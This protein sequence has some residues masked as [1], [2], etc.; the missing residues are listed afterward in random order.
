MLRAKLNSGAA[1]RDGE[2]CKFWR[3]D[4]EVAAPISGTR[5][6]LLLIKQV[7]QVSALNGRLPLAGRSLLLRRLD[8]QLLLCGFPEYRHALDIAQPWGAEDVVDRRRGPGKWV[9]RSNTIWLAPTSASRWRSPSGE[10]T[11]ES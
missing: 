7:D 8:S 6:D 2:V 5:P 9:V 11:I 1:Q 10:K 3:G 4:A